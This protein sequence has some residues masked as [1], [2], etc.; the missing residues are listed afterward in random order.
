[1]LILRIPLIYQFRHWSSGA[2]EANWQSV[3]YVK[4][5]ECNS[6]IQNSYCG[7]GPNLNVGVA[8]NENA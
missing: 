5:E 1:M 8:A 6:M 7:F 3:N 2:I 4:G